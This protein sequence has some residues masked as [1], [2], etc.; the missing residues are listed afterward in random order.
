MKGQTLWLTSTKGKRHLNDVN[1]QRLRTLIGQ[2]P[3][4]VGGWKQAEFQFS[5]ASA[6][7]FSP[8]HTAPALAS[9]LLKNAGEGLMYVCWQ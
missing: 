1:H 8:P 2:H 7:P 3:W 9:E 4:G 6:P 5:P